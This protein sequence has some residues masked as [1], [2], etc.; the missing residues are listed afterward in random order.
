MA[1]AVLDAI[2]RNAVVVLGS[3]VTIGGDTLA[4]DVGRG[5]GEGGEVVDGG[6]ADDVCNGRDNRLDKVKGFFVIEHDG[7]GGRA[8]PDEAA[9][10]I[11]GAEE[12]AAEVMGVV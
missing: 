11:G 1:T 4:V 7:D 10:F 9:H 2:G 3:A 5:G 8:N 12:G 6:A